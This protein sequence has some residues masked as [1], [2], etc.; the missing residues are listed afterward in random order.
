M[1]RISFAA[2]CFAGLALSAPSSSA[3]S[4]APPEFLNAEGK[5][6]VKR[7]FKATGQAGH[8]RTGV[9]GNETV[10]TCSQ[11]TA[12]GE[13]ESESSNKY[14]KTVVMVFT[15]CEAVT[16]TGSKCKVK[17]KGASTEGKIETETLGGRVGPVARSEASSRVGEDL[18]PSKGTL[19]AL[20][21]GTCLPGAS[22][23]LEGS[24]IGEVRPVNEPAETSKLVFTESAGKQAIQG[25]KTGR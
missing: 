2:L 23:S 21:E 8:L 17:S 7:A 19:F 16:E 14:V 25:F 10:I 6:V 12:S 20:L 1:K 13:I 5:A 24:V 4:A 9:L 11:N 22:T 15:G 3:A 18:K